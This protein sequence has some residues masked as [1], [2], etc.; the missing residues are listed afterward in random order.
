MKLVGMKS[1]FYHLSLKL[2]YFSKLFPYLR[3]KSR[4]EMVFWIMSQ[5]QGLSLRKPKATS[6][7][8]ETTFNHYNVS[9]F[10]SKLCGVMARYAFSPESIW[11]MNE[12]D[13]TSVQRPQ[14]IDAEMGK[15]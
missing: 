14:K 8:R 7:S 2:N 3:L 11:N 1:S 12:S 4:K 6:L 13:L 10:F 15:H 9:I 5:N